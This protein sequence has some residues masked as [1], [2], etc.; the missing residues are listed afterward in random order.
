MRILLGLFWLFAGEVNT[1]HF[2]PAIRAQIERAATEAKAHPRDIA[3]VA[4]LAMTLH[5]YQQYDAAAGAY[6]RAQ[7]LDPRN[8]D[9]PYLLGA[10]QVELGAFDAAVKLF[11]SALQLRPDNDR[12]RARDARARQPRSVPS[13]DRCRA[14]CAPP[15]ANLRAR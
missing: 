11:Q 12:P 8:F 14:G 15:H 2:Q 5:A 10:A 3:A 4:A 7:E 9:W 13:A 6:S 1:T